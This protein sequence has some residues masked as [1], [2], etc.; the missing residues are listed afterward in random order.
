MPGAHD[1]FFAIGKL[2]QAACVAIIA[3]I[4]AEVAER[5]GLI[6][7]HETL[8][9]PVAGSGWTGDDVFFPRFGAGSLPLGF[10]ISDGLTIS[11]KWVTVIRP[12]ETAKATS[13][14]P[15]PPTPPPSPTL[16][17]LVYKWISTWLSIVTSVS[18]RCVRFFEQHAPVAPQPAIRLRQ[19]EVFRGRNPRSHKASLYRKPGVQFPWQMQMVKNNVDTMIVRSS[20]LPA[21]PADIVRGIITYLEDHS[22][23]G[24]A[25]DEIAAREDELMRARAE[26]SRLQKLVPP[27]PQFNPNAATFQPPLLPS[28]PSF[29]PA[30]QPRQFY[31]PMGAQPQVRH[32]A[33]WPAQQAM[34][35]QRGSGPSPAPGQ[36]MEEWMKQHPQHE[37]RA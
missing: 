30:P 8:P 2:L 25:E 23:R 11:E 28:A 33:P 10:N 34:P 1:G 24:R 14:P 16:L 32:A 4:F 7:W 5:A 6:H 21:V 12:I 17:E 20:V 18:L 27:M 31:P 3:A 26:I 15:P 29:T 19:L 9:A 35:W 37:K 13:P 36:N 22:Y